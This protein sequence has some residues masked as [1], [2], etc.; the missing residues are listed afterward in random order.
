[1]IYVNEKHL[2]LF[3]YEVLII[4]QKDNIY[5]TDK[6]INN[7]NGFIYNCYQEYKDLFNIIIPEIRV[8]KKRREIISM[9]LVIILLQK[10]YG[11]DNYIK[12]VEEVGPEIDRQIN[13]LALM[14]D[15]YQNFLDEISNM[16]FTE[17]KRILH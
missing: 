14:F 13:E 10:Y 11:T 1:M 2:T 7:L 9:N 5:I 4:T 17:Y 15:N 8:T 6:L 12:L 3:L 16:N